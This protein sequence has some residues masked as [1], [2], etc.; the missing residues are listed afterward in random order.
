MV[1]EA[2]TADPAAMTSVPS[3]ALWLDARGR[4]SALRIATLALLIWPIVLAVWAWQM[5]IRF[6]ARPINDLIH[7]AGFWMLMFVLLSLAVT[8]L[9]RIARYGQL[10]DVR[11]M[12]GVGA[13]CYGFAHISLYFLDLMFD[14]GT[15]ATEIVA[16]IYLTVGFTALTGLAVL[17]AT[18][19]DGMTRA[20]GGLRWRKLHQLIYVIGVLGLIHFFQQTKLD[21]SIPTLF[22]GL[23]T[24]LMGYRLIAARW[25]GPAEIP[26]WLLLVLAL[27]ASALTFLGEAIGIGIKFGVSPLVV[28]QTTFDI[29]F[30]NLD[31]L[32]P[33]W[34]VLAIGLCVVILDLACARWRQRKPRPRAPARP[35]KQPAKETVRETA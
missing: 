12:I 14:F 17:A 21:E 27:A 11:R 1:R 22:A 25:K 30:D 26:S 15:I 24:W 7:R 13:F 29:D 19:T 16:R 9:R 28:L 33:G 10:V 23:F 8:P 32:R 5:E 3:Y 34:Y 20:L 2:F 6:S 31:M 4:V 35:T 18:S